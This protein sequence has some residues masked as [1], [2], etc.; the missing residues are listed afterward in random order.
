MTLQDKLESE[1]QARETLEREVMGLERRLETQTN[2]MV[3]CFAK[4]DELESQLASRDAEILELK[5]R[6]CLADE[7]F[8][9]VIENDKEIVE[10]KEHYE[11]VRADS[12]TFVHKLSIASQEI[13]TLRAALGKMNCEWTRTISGTVENKW[14]HSKTCLKCEA[15]Q[16]KPGAE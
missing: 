15:L 7:G 2:N 11:A 4:H 6:L 9:M 13:A 5:H 8:K 1:K 3:K 12:R 10:L 16:H 14:V